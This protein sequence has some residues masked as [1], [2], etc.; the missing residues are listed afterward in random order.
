MKIFFY[1]LSKIFGN[2]KLL[3]FIIAAIVINI[4]FLVYNEYNGD[5]S[6]SEY[7]AIWE[8]LNEMSQS[9]KGEF[10]QEKSDTMNE[11]LFDYDGVM[12]VSF[13]YTGQWYREEALI[14]Y[15]KGEVDQCLTYGDYLNSVDESADIMVEMPIFSDK[16]SFDYKNIMKTKDDFGRL[17]RR[18]LDPQPSKGIL[19]AVRFAFTDILAFILIL[20]F[21]V[22]LISREKE[23]EQIEL[24]RT[25]E[26]GGMALACSK[27]S[28]V[29]FSD[30]I[31]VFTLYGGS[32]LGG[33]FLYGFGDLNRDIQS[34]YGFFG[35]NLDITAGQFLV[36]FMLL[37]ILT[38]F[39][40]SALGFFLF[41]L[42][43]GSIFNI[44]AMVVI[45][46]TEGALY[47]FIEPS[48]I[49]ALFRQ[50]N[51][52]ST[53]DCGNLLGKYLNINL[54]G[55]P[56]FSLPV[57]IAVAAVSTVGFSVLGAAIFCVRRQA[58]KRRLKV[59]VPFGKHTRLLPHELYKTFIG[60][61]AL[62]IIGG[63]L[64]L[65]ILTYNPVKTSYGGISDY[66][67]ISYVDQLQ[68]EATEGKLEFIESEL[69]E[70]YK[71]TTESGRYRTEALERLKAH[72]LYLR[73]KNGLLFNDKGYD[74]LTGGNKQSDR[75]SACFMAVLI[76]IIAGYIYSEEYKTGAF[77]ILRAAQNGRSK[78]FLYKLLSAALASFFI[79]AIING[80][81]LYNTLSAY[82]TKYIFAPAHS[83]E[84][85]EAVGAMPIFWYLVLLELGRFAA[86]VLQSAVIFF[87]SSKVKSYS[88]T[89]I[90][91]IAAFAVPAI[92]AAAG[93]GFMDYF[94]LNPLLIG[95]VFVN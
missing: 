1:E 31:A 93:F 90:G 76:T 12:E 52:F 34:V 20:F 68:G 85:L 91:G 82:G 5:F 51:I 27:L 92:I 9:E 22:V 73:E 67:Y 55:V 69:R 53:A 26:K 35:S 47:F 87:I 61:K 95:N 42:M 45:T 80:T 70:A 23:L 7:N 72:A 25:S 83:M 4:A 77:R 44:A 94:L 50:I 60:G 15:V 58:A 33:Y 38:C 64:I 75:Y 41:S 21:L 65:T 79:M 74:L 39:A 49:F 81:E 89:V 14:N 78:T 86:L 43:S 10:I 6:P 71:D 28:A 17:E 2:L 19:T 57:S 46:A 36:Y 37:K 24:F 84:K 40:F 66:I 63:L 56:I 59:S 8:D 18:A 29:F 54:F 88:L 30:I 11:L 62:I 48:S 16:G 13:D 32:M 3:A